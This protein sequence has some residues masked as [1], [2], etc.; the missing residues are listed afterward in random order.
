MN[1]EETYKL[2]RDYSTSKDVKEVLYKHNQD[3]K[4]MQLQLVN[5]EE[6]LLNYINERSNQT[7][8]NIENLEK[9]LVATETELQEYIDQNIKQLEN[10]MLDVVPRL[11]ERIENL[12]K[13]LVNTEMELQDYI[14]RNIEQVLD[15]TVD[16]MSNRLSQPHDCKNTKMCST[17]DTSNS[18]SPNTD[19]SD[20]ELTFSDVDHLMM[21]LLR[22]LNTYYDSKDTSY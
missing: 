19:L 16:I 4:N 20:L 18:P 1:F 6:N 5:T 12:E 15:R 21:T 13:Q 2:F 10:V 11:W 3:L 9:Q 22:N 8:E 17:G 7:Q 14:D